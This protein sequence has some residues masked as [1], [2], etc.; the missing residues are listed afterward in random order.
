MKLPFYCDVDIE[1]GHVRLGPL[2]LSWF[3]SDTSWNSWGSLDVLWNFKYSFLFAF[4]EL[5]DRPFV[6]VRELDYEISAALKA[7]KDL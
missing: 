6:K 7:S 2:V 1:W 4:H 5:E 3:N